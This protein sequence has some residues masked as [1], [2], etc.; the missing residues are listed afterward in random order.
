MFLFRNK[1][2]RT[3]PKYHEKHLKIEIEIGDRTGEVR[4]SGILEIA[5]TR[6]GHM[7]SGRKGRR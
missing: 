4:A 2:N 6:N 3:H 1:V 5:V 7:W